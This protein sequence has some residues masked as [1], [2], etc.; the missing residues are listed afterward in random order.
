MSLFWK[1]K[2]V[3][4]S[5]SSTTAI[6]G[7]SN[8]SF[9]IA[10]ISLEFF[11]WGFLC[12]SIP[13]V[14]IPLPRNTSHLPRILRYLGLR[15][16][17][18]LQLLLR[19][20]P[21]SGSAERLV[22]KLRIRRLEGPSKEKLAHQATQK[23]GWRGV[24][25]MSL[26]A[27]NRSSLALMLLAG[28]GGVRHLEETNMLKKKKKKNELYRRVLVPC[29]LLIWLPPKPTFYPERG[30]CLERW[31]ERGEIFVDQ[32]TRPDQQD[33]KDT[34]LVWEKRNAQWRH[35]W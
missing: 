34:Y 14:Y 4:P 17:C 1:R 15:M 9:L 13:L 30:C 21:N 29:F 28:K 20:I 31:S 25:T 24:S 2:S 8:T 7:E 22:D 12:I 27:W 10:W 18:F 11:F 16:T 33:T 32:S 19:E 23:S 5:T 35:R 3:A 26:V 6:L